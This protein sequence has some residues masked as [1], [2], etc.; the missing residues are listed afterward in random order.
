MP[1]PP[2]NRRASRAAVAVLGAAGL[3][4]LAAAPAA[5]GDETAP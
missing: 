5:F 3:I 4:V 2:H 1:M